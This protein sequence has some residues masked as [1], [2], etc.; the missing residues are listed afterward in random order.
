MTRYAH[1]TGVFHVD[2]VPGQA[3]IAHCHGLFVFPESRGQ[4]FG[5]VLKAEQMELLD[6]LGF[7]LGTCTVDAGNVA[8]KAVLARAGWKRLITFHNRRS[9]TQTELWAWVV[10]A[11]MIPADQERTA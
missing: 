5:H 1:P 7:D 8:Q 4:G 10:G 3:Q 9:D 6:D 2:P 11:D